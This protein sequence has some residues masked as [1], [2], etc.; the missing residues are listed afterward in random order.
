LKSFQ[1]IKKI[2]I[3]NFLKS[4]KS[5]NYTKILKNYIKNSKTNFHSALKKKLSKAKFPNFI[6]ISLQLNLIEPHIS[7]GE[8]VYAVTAAEDIILSS[9]FI[10]RKQR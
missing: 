8:F 9:L 10:G 5:S 4:Y 7:L 1:K 6:V 2:Y 3:R